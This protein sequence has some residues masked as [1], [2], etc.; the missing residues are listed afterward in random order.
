MASLRRSCP[1]PDGAAVVTKIGQAA[2][3]RGSAERR[4]SDSEAFVDV[5]TQIRPNR[6]E[7]DRSIRFRLPN[8][9]SEG[10]DAPLVG[11][12]ATLS[13]IRSALLGVGPGG[14]AAVFLTGES[15]VGK[16]RLL[17]ETAAALAAHG[18]GGLFGAC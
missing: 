1:L 8:M 10:D 3:R 12:D 15:G 11:R 5:V 17:R 2:H 4:I 7:R 16:S 6:R 18:V 13:E 9:A 14:T